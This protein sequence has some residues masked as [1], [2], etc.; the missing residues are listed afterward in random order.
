MS[1][2]LVIPFLIA[3]ATFQ[4]LSAYIGYHIGQYR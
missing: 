4:V 3:L 1:I 2:F